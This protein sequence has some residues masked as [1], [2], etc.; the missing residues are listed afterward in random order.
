MNRGENSVVPYRGHVAPFS[1]NVSNYR[2]VALFFSQFI[3]PTVETKLI[4]TL[5][6]FIHC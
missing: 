5:L 2:I 3:G 6:R 1:T 4:F